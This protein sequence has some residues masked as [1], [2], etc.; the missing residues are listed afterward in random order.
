[1]GF[2]YLT[3]GAQQAVGAGWLILAIVDILWLLFLTSEK[4]TL[5][6]HLL[7]HPSISHGNQLVHPSGNRGFSAPHQTA[8]VGYSSTHGGGGGGKRTS[9]LAEINPSSSTANGF[10]AGAG[11]G[12]GGMSTDHLREHSPLVEMGRGGAN[13]LAAGESQ[14]GLSTSGGSVP[15]G[16]I[17]KRAKALYACEFLPPTHREREETFIRKL[18]NTLSAPFPSTSCQNFPFFPRR[19]SKRRRPPRDLNVQRRAVRRARQ[20]R[21]VVAGRQARRVGSVRDR[22]VELPPTR[23]ISLPSASPLFA[24]TPSS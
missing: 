21:K 5:F 2:I 8:G 7:N 23:L 9:S 18:T 3:D 12:G 22:T 14:G 4:P 17:T 19:P 24:H 13:G 16:Q 15:G 10:Y 6:N 1:M 11:G 20:L